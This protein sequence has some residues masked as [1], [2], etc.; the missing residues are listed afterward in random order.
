[1]LVNWNDLWKGFISFG[2]C[3]CDKYI[4]VQKMEKEDLET[5]KM[6][7]FDLYLE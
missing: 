4:G 2:R 1:M 3:V 6:T 7:H 5:I